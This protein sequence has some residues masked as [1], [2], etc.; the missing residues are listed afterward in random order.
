MTF[1]GP[2]R[3]DIFAVRGPSADWLIWPDGRDAD[4]HP[5]I[6]YVLGVQLVPAGSGRVL[7]HG[8]VR[9]GVVAA[10]QARPRLV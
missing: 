3:S 5:L 8:D 6:A 9:R 2:P 7:V 1:T 10:A 4:G